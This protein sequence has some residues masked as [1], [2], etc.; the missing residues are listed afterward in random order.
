MQ[1]AKVDLAVG[2]RGVHPDRHL[3]L[4]DHELALPDR[5]RHRYRLPAAQSGQRTAL[6]VR[7]T[8]WRQIGVSQRVQRVSTSYT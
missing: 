7:V 2:N 8:Q 5:A 3:L 6:R 4:A 1:Q